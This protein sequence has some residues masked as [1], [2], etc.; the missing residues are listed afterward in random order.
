MSDQ[1]MT[2]TV[3]NRLGRI[4]IMVWPRG[5]HNEWDMKFVLST[6]E[7]L[8]LASDLKAVVELGPRVAC[9]ADLGLE[10]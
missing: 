10:A 5:Q 2:V 1:A 3:G 9:S 4:S 6:D 8:K 7:A